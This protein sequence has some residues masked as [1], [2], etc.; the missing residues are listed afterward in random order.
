LAKRG[1]RDG[2]P[3]G[4]TRNG[5]LAGALFPAAHKF[6]WGDIR[7]SRSW[8][9]VALVAAGCGLVAVAGCG[10][11]AGVAEDATVAVYV[12]APLC[13]EAEKQA[14]NRG[15]QAGELRVRVVCLPAAEAKGRLDL[16]Q[17]G[18]NAR[19]AVQDA[20]T[21]GYIGEPTKAATRF[22]QPV[23]ETAEIPQLSRASGATA[24]SQ[25]LQALEE[26][27]TSSSLRQS[28]N[29]SLS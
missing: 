8:R 24:M 18:A 17:I 4:G 9:K 6:L 16:A 19:Q 12:A 28:I 21:V 7:P 11:G 22:S 29:D 15:N 14:A 3:P 27:D 13:A 1:G 10:E 5:R 26:A 20:S 23:L 25:L 2:Y